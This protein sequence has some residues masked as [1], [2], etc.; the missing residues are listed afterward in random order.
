MTS[1]NSIKSLTLD[2]PPSCIEFSPTVPS[3]FV[4][5]TYFLEKKDQDESASNGPQKRSGSLLVFQLEGD[6]M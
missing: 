6:D 3:C 4:V 2:L 5:G 1:I